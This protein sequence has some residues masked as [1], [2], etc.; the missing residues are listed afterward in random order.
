MTKATA[1][2]VVSVPGAQH[3]RVVL[4]LLALAAVTMALVAM[5]L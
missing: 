5:G 4:G 2:A 1:I 3:V